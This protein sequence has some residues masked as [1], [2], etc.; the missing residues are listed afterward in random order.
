[1]SHSSELVLKVNLI[2]SFEA[3]PFSVLVADRKVYSVVLE[4]AE[5]TVVPTPSSIVR[6]QVPEPDFLMA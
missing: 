4:T 6:V 1:M 3:L 5:L 2:S